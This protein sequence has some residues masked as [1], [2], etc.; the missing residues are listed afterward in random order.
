[1]GARSRV[2]EARHT[3][4]MTLRKAKAGKPTGA[5][6]LSTVALLPKPAMVVTLVLP[7]AVRDSVSGRLRAQQIRVLARLLPP[8]RMASRWRS[9]SSSALRAPAAFDKTRGHRC[10]V[11][12]I[13]DPHLLGVMSV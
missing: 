2:M 7:D 5:I 11:Q 9:A 13:G 1:M 12:C 8:S 10:P 4:E 6:A 3:A